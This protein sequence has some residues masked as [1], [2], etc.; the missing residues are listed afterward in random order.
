MKMF[1]T[2]EYIQLDEND[3]HEVECRVTYVDGTIEVFIDIEDLQRV[4]RQL[5]RQALMRS[6]PMNT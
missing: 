5:Q 2:V 4:K 3:P 1:K 6:N